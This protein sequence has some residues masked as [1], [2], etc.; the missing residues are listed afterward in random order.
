M[1]RSD[2]IESRGSKR[3]RLHGAVLCAGAALCFTYLL[4]GCSK[5]SAAAGPSIVQCDSV[6]SKILDHP[7]DYC[8]DLPANYATSGKRYPV[9]YFLHGLFGNDHRWIDRG[10]KEIFDRLTADGTIGQFIVVLPN[11]GETFYIN[12]E[13]G[14][15]RY[16]DFFVQELV[17]FVD[18]HYRT[19]ATREARGISGLSMGGYGALHLAMRHPDLFGSVAATSAVLIPALPNP[20]PTEGRWQFYLRILSHAFGSPLN[21]AY[22]EANSPLTLAK[23]PSKFQGL[24][25]YFDVG[26]QDRYGFEKGAAMLDQILDKENYPHTYALRSGGHGWEFLDQYMKYSLGFQWHWLKQAEQGTAVKAETDTH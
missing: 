22:W 24:K 2:F 14:K 13:D 10:G 16:E 15:D 18:H 3:Q 11:G 6:P 19:I 7:V 21:Q 12:S 26:D 20:I 8:V 23:D 5:V 25:I 17:P 1:T 4:I 9:L